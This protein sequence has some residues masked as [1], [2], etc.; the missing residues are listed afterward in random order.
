MRIHPSWKEFLYPYL[1]LENKVLLPIFKEIKERP[2]IC[3]SKENIFNIF[4]MPKDKI[5]VVWVFQDPY[6]NP[7]LANGIALSVPK[8]Q[9]SPSL[10]VI[11]TE[12]E[13][14]YNVELDNFD[15]SLKHWLKQGV[16]LLN[17]SLTCRYFRPGSHTHLWSGFIKDVLS[18]LNEKPGLVYVFSGKVAQKGLEYVSEHSNYVFKTYHPAADKH[19]LEKK[20]FVGCDIFKKIDDIF[21]KTNGPEYKINWV[22]YN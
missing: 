17:M 18:H 13:R 4:R 9:T 6:P 1:S 11:K 8:G 19:Q 20:L 7:K 16:F 3:P 22:S 2:N 10:E 15:N 14:S 21:E 12:L 5:R